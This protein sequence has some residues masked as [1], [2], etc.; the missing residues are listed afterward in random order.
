LF[1]IFDVENSVTGVRDHSRSSKMA[2]F[3]KWYMVSY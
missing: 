2:P 3:D 1:E